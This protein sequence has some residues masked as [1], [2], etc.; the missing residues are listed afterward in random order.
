M[1][2]I[3]TSYGDSHRMFLQGLMSSQRLPLPEATELYSRIC[4]SENI[5]RPVDFGNFIGRINAETLKYGFEIKK[6][7]DPA[8]GIDCYV[9]IHLIV[10]DEDDSPFEL[11]SLK[12]LREAAHLRPVMTKQ[13]AEQFIARLV[14]DYWLLDKDGKLSLGIRSVVELAPFLRE[15]RRPALRVAEPADENSNSQQESI[16]PDIA[17]IKRDP[18][19]GNSAEQD[20]QDE[21]QDMDEDEQEVRTL[22]SRL[23]RSQASSGK[24][25]S[26]AASSSRPTKRRNVQ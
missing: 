19:Q 23:P 3:D 24:S 2:A 1:A 8:T 14:R 18:D 13:D 15:E 11:S 25:S 5:A 7:V 26:T 17:A 16:E 4:R 20:V 10:T 12:A 21:R 22:R 6:G 9:L